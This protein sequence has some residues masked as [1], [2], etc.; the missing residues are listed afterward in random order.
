MLN[1]PRV[2]LFA[3]TF[4]EINGAAGVLRRLENYANE[5][6]YPFLCIRAGQETK[7]SE[8][9][10]SQILELR[11]G[12]C[13]LPVDG[14]L[15]YDPLF[16]RYRKIVGRKLG[17]FQPDVIH[18]TGLNDVSQLGFF[19]AHV[20]DIAAVASWHTNTHEY[21]ARR[22]LSRFRWLPR[23]LQDAI[24]RG[25]E[26]GTMYG[27]M[28]LYFL[29]QVQLAPNEELTRQIRKMTRRPSFL[30][31]RGV[32]LEFFDPAKRS[33]K[34]STF[35]LGY[36]GRLRPEKNVRFFAEVEKAL[37]AAGIT[38]FKIVLIGEGSESL[39][40]KD[41]LQNV[42]LTGV[43]R[44]EKLA[45]AYADMDLFVF[46]SETDAFGNVVLE[47]MASGVPAIVMP[48]GGPK[49]LIKDSVNGFVAS[50]EARFLETVVELA[51]NRKK[52]SSMRRE[53]RRAACE[54]SWQQVFEDLYDRYHLSTMVGKKVRVRE[55]SMDTVGT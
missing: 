35:V 53:A 7:F 26:K 2:A 9:G 5:N 6:S 16:W 50:S 18:V 27:L 32:D 42:E 52:I 37:L 38:G 20:R 12:R 45:R 21:T 41:N 36:V 55:D 25:I 8:E 13:S 40:L 44:G 22:L 39:W 24:S 30:M 19:F 14:E 1:T 4:H 31:A 47:A 34:D 11:R 48:L 46:P 15:E 28:R 29:A 23:R 33:R 10:N 54:R 43:L 49:F 51:R 17:E 3:D